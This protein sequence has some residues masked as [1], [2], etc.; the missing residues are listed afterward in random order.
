MLQH[1][2]KMDVCR[3]QTDEDDMAGRK[4]RVRTKRGSKRNTI[5]L[6]NARREARKNK[7]T[8]VKVRKNIDASRSFCDWFSNITLNCEQRTLG[9]HRSDLWTSSK[10]KIRKRRLKRSERNKEI[11]KNKQQNNK[12]VNQD[13]QRQQEQDETRHLRMETLRSTLHHLHRS[14]SAHD[15]DPPGKDCQGNFCN[16]RLE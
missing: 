10:H 16:L 4:R 7:R 3:A 8:E 12:Y 5:R 14:L 1:P 13:Y 15:V 2:C 6:R 9:S 11:K